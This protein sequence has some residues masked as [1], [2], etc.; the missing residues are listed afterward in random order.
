[1]AVA[2]LWAGGTVGA[3]GHAMLND[4]G[5]WRQHRDNR[6]LRSVMDGVALFVAA[7]ASSFAILAVLLT[8]PDADYTNLR[9]LLS[10]IAWGSFGAA[11]IIRATTRRPR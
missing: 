11:G 3:F 8:T 9:K 7:V 2:L 4:L 10:G 6:A 5:E 1:M